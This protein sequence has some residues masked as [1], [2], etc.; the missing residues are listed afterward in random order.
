MMKIAVCGLV[1]VIIR[2]SM[3]LERIL[4]M[5]FSARSWNQR[6]NPRLFNDISTKWGTKWRLIELEESHLN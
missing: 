5:E 2:L 1:I 3:S 4:L 6:N